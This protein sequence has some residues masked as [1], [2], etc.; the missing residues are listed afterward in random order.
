MTKKKCTTCK[1]KDAEY[2]ACFGCIDKHIV[3]DGL[4][5]YVSTYLSRSSAIQLKLAV[6]GFYGEEAIKEAR[7]KLYTAVDGIVEYD[8]TA[9]QNSVTRSA[10]E[11]ELDDILEVFKRIDQL[12]EHDLKF[13]VG[14]ITKL[15]PAAPEAGGTVMSLLESM[16][17]MQNTLIQL[18]Q[19]VCSIRTDVNAQ[20]EDIQQ[21]KGDLKGIPPRSSYASTLAKDPKRSSKAAPAGPGIDAAIVSKAIDDVIKN[22]QQDSEDDGFI[23]VG[24]KKS[25]K[26]M[27]DRRQRSAAGTAV[28]TGRVMAGPESFQVQLTN[29]HP[30]IVVDDIQGFITDKD[31]S[32]KALDIRDMSSDGWET[33]RFVVSFDSEI[34]DT[35]MKNDF[36]PARIYYKRWYPPRQNKPK[37]TGAGSFTTNNG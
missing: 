32:I 6:L 15:P 2:F 11:V 4:L 37:S 28:T 31:S 9:R 30:S 19:S 16:A 3:I 21:V 22:D 1:T 12:Q 23:K 27:M 36:W 26:N 13:Y 18:E 7:G 25:K 24:S 20:A 5:C 35:V 10:K 29:V 14:D 17:K 33:K 34:T 8:D